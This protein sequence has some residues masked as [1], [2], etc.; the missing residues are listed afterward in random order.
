MIIGCNLDRVIA[1]PSRF[2]GGLKSF[3]QEMRNRFFQGLHLVSDVKR[4]LDR[5]V[6]RHEVMIVTERSYEDE[7]ITSTWLAE[8]KI[9]WSTLGSGSSSDRYDFFIEDSIQRARVLAKSGVEVLWMCPK[10]RGM[11]GEDLRIHRM[12][13]WKEIERF[14]EDRGVL[15]SSAK[16]GE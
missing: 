9:S 6:E 2:P 15:P 8:N 4:V 13:D 16:G 11:Y 10:W 5:L 7:P 1:E 14:F 12:K 3:S